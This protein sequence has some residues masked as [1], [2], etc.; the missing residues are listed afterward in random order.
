MLQQQAAKGED[1]IWLTPVA[2][3]QL[4]AMAASS[5]P[6]TRQQ[7]PAT[8]P[9]TQAAATTSQPQRDEAPRN[10]AKIER[11]DL[12]KKTDTPTPSAE[13]LSPEGSTKI[14]KLDWL[15]QRAQNWEPARKLDSLR[16]TMVFSVGNPDARIV[17]VGE[18]P[19]AEEERQ[20]EP[21]VGPAGQLL[22]KIIEAMGIPRAD[23]YISNIVKFRPALPNQGESNRKP[24][25]EEMASCVA[26]VKTEIEVIQPDVV[27][28]LGGTAAEGLLGLSGSVS[29]MRSQ[30]HDLSGIPTMVTFHPS[31]LLRNKQLTERRKVWEDMLMVMEKLQLPI[32]PKQRA[33]FK[34]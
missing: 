15:K 24:T 14:E 2:R 11:P 30:F 18:A 12:G 3:K 20:R 8:S 1:H 31:Y 27:V 21:F 28:A 29:R 22:T 5:A 16:D 10:V 23:V 25:S 19:G 9:R 7:A 6:Q 33:Y 26:F 32:S 34:K 13:T 17:F 4:R